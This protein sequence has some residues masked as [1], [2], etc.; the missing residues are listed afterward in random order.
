LYWCGYGG[1]GSGGRLRRRRCGRVVETQQVQQRRRSG[2][3]SYSASGYSGSGAGD[4]R[5][6]SGCSGSSGSGGG[7]GAFL[8]G[9]E[10]GV[11]SRVCELAVLILAPDVVLQLA[12]LPS[13][14]IPRQSET[15]CQTSR[16]IGGQ[17]AS[18]RLNRR[19]FV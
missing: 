6:G 9:S 3:G 4:G 11:A 5:G 16:G 17:Y 19:R 1:N 18:A 2:G 12:L 8:G 10:R 14:H 15:V 13:I 7:G